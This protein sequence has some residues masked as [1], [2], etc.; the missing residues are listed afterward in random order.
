M[1]LA[2]TARRIRW[3]TSRGTR[4]RENPGG[5]LARTLDR[6]GEEALLDLLEPG[7]QQVEL[8]DGS[9][10]MRLRLEP[11]GV[12][13]ES[14]WSGGEALHSRLPLPAARV[15]ESLE[16]ALHRPELALHVAEGRGW[17]GRPS[18]SV[19]GYVPAVLPDHLGSAAFRRCY[20][21]ERNIMAGAMAGGIASVELVQAMAAG[22]M[23]G[24]FGAGGLDLGEVE[25]AVDR[26][27]ADGG[28][29]GVNLLHNPVEPAME[30]RSVDLFLSR[31]VRVV[32]ASAFMQLTHPVL[33]YRLA[34]IEERDGRVYVPNRLI[35]K[36]SRPEVAEPFLRP[37][38]P[39]MVEELREAGHL[40]ERQAQ[41]AKYVT[42]CDDL[43]IEADSGGHTDRRP[44]SVLSPAIRRLRDRI[45]TECATARPPRIGAAGGLGDPWSI[46]AAFALGADY[47]VTGSVNQSTREAGTS[48]AV[49]ELL[50]AANYTDVGMGP[51]PD[52]F[53]LGA[54][55]QVLSR[56]S[57]YAQ[58]AGKLYEVYRGQ[59]S[60]E[61]T[62]A[63]ERDRIEKHILGRT[64]ADVWA[65]T[66]SYWSRRDPRE[67]ERAALDPRHRMA[68]AFRWYL[69]MSSRWARQGESSR[70][71][72]YQIWC[73]PAMGLFNDWVRGTW[74]EPL[75]ARSVAT[76]NRALLHG[77]AVATRLNIARLTGMSLPP[78]ALRI[79][80]HR[81]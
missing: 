25:R 4:E 64:F 48:R 5:M 74:L 21:V 19:T 16:P 40:T 81:S 31:G 12:A 3:T 11:D 71:R 66:E 80:P 7:V 72:D 26:L 73:G 1:D 46:A 18:S 75:E 54:E 23:L 39:A 34:G 67:L 38:P 57:M 8:V 50:A 20:R 27:V 17:D 14:Q 69:G 41:L 44:L 68:L 35:A 13:V 78:E 63:H 77:A 32:E 70:K 2:T 79:V 45:A 22:G 60:W 58:R 24:I 28:N 49:K 65:D 10:S 76:V 37:P 36:V 42:V 61:Q 33:R 52:M 6:E 15:V 30:E 59:P 29:F 62:P 9:L 51:A 55:V 47:V 53:E 56:G 43:T